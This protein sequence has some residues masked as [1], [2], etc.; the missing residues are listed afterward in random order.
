MRFASDKNSRPNA[1]TSSSIKSPSRS[2]SEQSDEIVEKAKLMALE[3]IK[4]YVKDGW[5]QAGDTKWLTM[6]VSA[7]KGMLWGAGLL[8]AI[9]VI[10]IVFKEPLKADTAAQ[11]A[12]VA[13][14]VVSD[15]KVQE[16]VSELSKG[17]VNRILQDDTSV[18]Q[19]VVL[20]QKL[21]KQESTQT[22][23]SELLK[24]LFLDPHT[25]ANAQKFVVEILHDEYVNSPCGLSHYYLSSSIKNKIKKTNRW[26]LDNVVALVRNGVYTLEQDKVLKDSVIEFLAHIINDTLASPHV[27]A[28]TGQALYNAAKM[29]VGLKGSPTCPK[30]KLELQLDNDNTVLRNTLQQTRLEIAKLQA[31][32][33]SLGHGVTKEKVI[34]KNSSSEIQKG[35]DTETQ[36]EEHPAG[37]TTT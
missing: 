33:V 26:V 14:R 12:D 16:E 29:G 22:T 37:A 35:T 18:D 15:R 19:I 34:I 24:N 1:T 2:T 31:D 13:S 20:L 10:L 28:A 30:T 36:T 27:Q 23:L 25:K 8:I 21:V 6:A 7:H 4:K 3:E 32:L 9:A 17:V 5:A 11:T